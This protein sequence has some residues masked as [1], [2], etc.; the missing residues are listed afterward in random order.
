MKRL[1]IAVALAVAAL[2]G[3]ATMSSAPVQ[4]VAAKADTVI[5]TAERG[6][7]V[8]ELAYTTAADGVGI[9]VDSGAIRGA[10]ATTVRGWNATARGLL[11]RG[12]A[13]AD[14]AEKA[15]IAA[16]LLSIAANLNGLKGSK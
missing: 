1:M 12:K 8:G 16:Q 2:T 9:L 15:R 6:F 7:A 5:L 14:K 4:G 10:T 13:T 11:V 3:C